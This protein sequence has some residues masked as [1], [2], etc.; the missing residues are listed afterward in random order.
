MGFL[1]WIREEDGGALKRVLKSNFN[2]VADKQHQNIM[3]ELTD[4]GFLGSINR[5]FVLGRIHIWDEVIDPRQVY[6]E[7]K[8]A[9]LIPRGVILTC[10]N[11]HTTR[12]DRGK[13]LITQKRD[14][15]RA[16]MHP[17]SDHGNIV[18]AAFKSF[19]FL[20]SQRVKTGY[21]P[22]LFLYDTDGHLAGWEQVMC[23]PSEQ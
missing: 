16:E 17:F 13:R 4:V 19:E 9:P 14:I 7:C 23:R 1:Y 10:Y 22:H 8:P 18:E 12:I 6:V 15:E 20:H 21:T 3:G 11:G 2:G 5:N